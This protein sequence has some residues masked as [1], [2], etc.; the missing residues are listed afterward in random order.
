MGMVDAEYGL[1]TA[2]SFYWG[3][4][5]NPLANLTAYVGSRA[6]RVLSL[7]RFAGVLERAVCSPGSIELAFNGAVQFER[8]RAQWEWVNQQEGNYVVLVTESAGL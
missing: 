4:D 3:P 7:E 2:E 5:G 1:R 6:V 8:V